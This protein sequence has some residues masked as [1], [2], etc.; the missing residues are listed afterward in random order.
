MGCCGA[1]CRT[2][3]VLLL[4]VCKG[5]KL[6]YTDG[7]RDI[8]KAKCKMK[9]CCVGKNL[10]SCADC[11]KYCECDI[12][13]N[14]LKNKGY[15]YIK[16]KQALDYIRKEGYELFFSFADEWENA[17]GKYKKDG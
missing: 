1:Y 4:G 8:N 11:E 10:N 5:C 13:G 14:F 16:Y 17:Y 9:V 3:K 2:C 7:T 15:K 6:G 12:I